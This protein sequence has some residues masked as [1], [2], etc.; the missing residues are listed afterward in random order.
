MSKNH[1]AA[2]SRAESR[3]ARAIELDANRMSRGA[4]TRLEGALRDLTDVI[5]MEKSKAAVPEGFVRLNVLMNTETTRELSEMRNLQL[6]KNGSPISFAD[7]V[8]RAM[9]L[10]RFLFSEWQKGRVVRTMRPDGTD[11]KELVLLTEEDR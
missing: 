5:A 11:C 9:S 8:R 10:S 1:I 3:V 4:K 6:G 7:T 2:L